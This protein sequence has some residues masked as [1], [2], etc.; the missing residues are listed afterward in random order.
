MTSKE[1]RLQPT[2]EKP[3]I[4]G[5]KITRFS[6]IYNFIVELVLAACIFFAF[7]DLILLII[8]YAH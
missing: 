2:E 5:E 1:K 8:T 6:Q 7:F 4:K 3:L